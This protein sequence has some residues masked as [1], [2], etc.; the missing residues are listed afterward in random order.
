MT[1]RITS[2]ALSVLA[3]LCFFC[4]SANP[5]TTYTMPSPF[6]CRCGIALSGNA[7]LPI[8]APRHTDGGQH[9]KI[10]GSFFFTAASETAEVSLP[11]VPW[12][13]NTYESYMATLIPVSFTTPSGNNPGTFEFNWRDEDANGVLH[14]GTASGTWQDQVICDGRRCAWRAPKLLT[15][16]TTVN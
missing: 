12:P 7:V 11:G 1:R 4:L 8:L 16:S 13:P 15:F 2:A 10:V 9:G 3:A 5:Q 6:L 14:S